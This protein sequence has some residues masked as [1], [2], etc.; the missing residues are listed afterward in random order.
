MV[1]GQQA[2]SLTF[3]FLILHD[4]ATL[5]SPDAITLFH[6]KSSIVAP[7]P[8]PSSANLVLQKAT[9]PSRS[10]NPDDGGYGDACRY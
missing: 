7:F 2:S 6:H 4:Y 1:V 10:V 3:S 9:K 5:Y 8:P